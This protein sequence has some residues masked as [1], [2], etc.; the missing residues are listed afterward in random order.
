MSAENDHTG[1]VRFMSIA[2]CRKLR[3]YLDARIEYFDNLPFPKKPLEELG[4][5]TRSY[6]ALKNAGLN[7]ME[8]VINFGLGNIIILQGIG[9]RSVEEIR[10]LVEQANNTTT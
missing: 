4:L 6:N 3:D 5:S 10:M 2:E 9:T 8:D 7:T 1:F